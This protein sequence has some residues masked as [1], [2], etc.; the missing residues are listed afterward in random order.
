MLSIFLHHQYSGF[1]H[2]VSNKTTLYAVPQLQSRA[3]I[4]L[5]A[6]KTS[7]SHITEINPEAVWW[8]ED[9][10]DHPLCPGLQPG[11]PSQTPGGLDQ[12][13]W[14]VS[15]RGH[16]TSESGVSEVGV[17]RALQPN[18]LTDANKPIPQIP[19]CICS[20]FHNAPFR[21]EMCT[22]LFWMVHWGICNKCIVWLVQQVCCEY[23]GESWACYSRT[24]L[25]EVPDFSYQ[26][27]PVLSS[28]F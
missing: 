16:V 21:T 22:F 3:L 13:C 2:N 8:G 11:P 18:E 19:Q 24:V 15:E 14:S 12:R 27:L 1:Y 23:S 10:Y 28:W 5:R 4:E 9:H 20:V 17:V 6:H 7:A 25:Y 26:K